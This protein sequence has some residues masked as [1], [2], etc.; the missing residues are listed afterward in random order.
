MSGDINEA[1]HIMMAKLTQI[2]GVPLQY[3]AIVN[4]E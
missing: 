1:A 4:F 3:Y 2:T